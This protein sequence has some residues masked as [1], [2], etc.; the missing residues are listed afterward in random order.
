MAKEVL[1]VVPHDQEWAVKRAGVD[2]ADSTH[3][4]QKDA[5]EAAREQAKERDDIVIHRPDG[6][7]RE[8]VTYMG[9]NGQSNEVEERGTRS[10]RAGDR[11]DI[12]VRD[13][14]S[15]GSRVSWG[16]VLAGVM[17]ALGL[18]VTF[19]AL[20][21]ATGLSLADRADP[22]NVPIGAAIVAA[23]TLL[24]AM[25]LG[26]F[27]AS[28]MTVG[29]Q[30]SEAITYGVLV[31]GTVLLLLAIGGTSLGLNLFDNARAG[32]AT[33]AST[34]AIPLERL[35][36]DLNL[37]QQQA[38]RY[39]Q[40]VNESR[41]DTGTAES[42]AWWTFAT[43]ALSLLAAIGGGIAGAGPEFVLRGF[44]RETQPAAVAPRPA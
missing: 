41:R 14:A 28:R 10:T 9:P 34:S 8:R 37:N 1:H 2:R 25:F 36:Q 20:A 21:I 19:S 39:S 44:R 12:H 18:Y 17:V 5:I 7:I 43:L 31:W 40:M 32:D 29:E 11:D 30:T 23:V 22:N 3:S 42:V 15:V 33:A 13:V 6:T 26:G 4:T 27:V 35:Q 16:A 24:A 38:D